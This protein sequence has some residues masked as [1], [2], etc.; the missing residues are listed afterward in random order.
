MNVQRPTTSNAMSNGAAKRP[1]QPP[2]LGGWTL[3]V[4]DDGRDPE[5]A[6]AA[7]RQAGWCPA[8][9]YWPTHPFICWVES[10]PRYHRHPD[11]TWAA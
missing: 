1:V 9:T 6:R 10:C 2:P 3:D 5:S 8:H 7:R 4:L 11:G